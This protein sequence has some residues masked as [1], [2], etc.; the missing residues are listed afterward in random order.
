MECALLGCRIISVRPIDL[1]TRM[2]TLEAGKK[3]LHID[4]IP[5]AQTIPFSAI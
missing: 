5:Y 1:R 4:S 2:V 3:M